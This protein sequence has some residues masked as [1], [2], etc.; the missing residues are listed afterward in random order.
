[1]SEF[2]KKE[3]AGGIILI[4]A[5]LVALVAANSRLDTYYRQLLSTAVEVRIGTDEIAKPLVLWINDRVM[6]VFFD[7]VSLE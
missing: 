4:F 1:M 6:A 3:S 7:R 5:A 2:L